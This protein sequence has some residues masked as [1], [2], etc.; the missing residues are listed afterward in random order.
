M[1]TVLA[2]TK[3]GAEKI[4]KSFER[5]SEEL[6]AKNPLL[7]ENGCNTEILE[8]ESDE[9]GRVDTHHLLQKMKSELNVNFAEL[10]AG[11]ETIAH[12]IYLKNVDEYRKTTAG[13]KKKFL[14]YLFY[15]YFLF[16]YLFYFYF[17]LFLFIL[18][19]Y[20]F[21]LFYF[22]FFIFLFLFILFILFLFLFIFI[23]FYLFLFIFIYFILFFYNFFLLGHLMGNLNSVGE[24]RSLSFFLQ[25]PLC[26]NS[27]N[28]PLLNYVGIRF[29]GKYLIFVRSLIE[30]RN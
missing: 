23:Y 16:F 25:P 15:F 26:F 7:K 12:W 18:F 30:Y 22:Y 20:L 3:E 27:E 8:V 29:Y 4:R 11:G 21:Y 9:K 13:K 28:N 14:F 5:Q 2:T 24:K 19:F 10:T 17:Y 1:R 6:K